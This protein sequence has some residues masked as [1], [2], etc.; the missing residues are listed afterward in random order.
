MPAK[1]KPNAPL[2]EL[3]A[4]RLRELQLR[5]Q[6]LERELALAAKTVAKISEVDS[7]LE[8]IG[9]RTHSAMRFAFETELPPKAAGQDVVAIREMAREAVDRV[10]LGLQGLVQE[11]GKQYRPEPRKKT[12]NAKAA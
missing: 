2:D 6:K 5:C 11:W 8:Y 7:L 9:R 3:R 4:A 10:A 12:P 1:R